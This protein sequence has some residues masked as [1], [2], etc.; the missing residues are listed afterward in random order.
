MH[1]ER[2]ITSAYPLL[3]SQ[4]NHNVVVFIFVTIWNRNHS[5]FLSIVYGFENWCPYPLLLPAVFISRG[6]H[7]HFRPQREKAVERLSCTKPRAVPPICCWNHPISLTHLATLPPTVQ[8][9]EN[10]QSVLRP[11]G[12]MN[13]NDRGAD[14]AVAYSSRMLNKA[15]NVGEEM[16]LQS[17]VITTTRVLSNAFRPAFIAPMSRRLS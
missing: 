15:G 1:D 6:P 10:C 13:T 2:D 12:A 3:Q 9:R 4:Q 8:S 14:L 17:C 7:R 11:R 5:S 16:V